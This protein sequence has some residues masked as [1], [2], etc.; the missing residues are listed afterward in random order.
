MA[1]TV[2]KDGWISATKLCTGTAASACTAA[3]IK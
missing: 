3:G 1:N 2:I